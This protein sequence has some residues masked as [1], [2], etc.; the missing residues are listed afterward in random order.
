MA[1]GPDLLRRVA[2]TH[3]RCFWIDRVHPR[4]WPG[5]GSVVGWLANEDVSIAYDAAS[6]TVTRHVGGRREVVGD[7]VWAVLDAEVAAGPDDVLWVGYLGYAARPDLPAR[8]R[9]GLPDAVWL[10][11]DPRRMQQVPAGTDAEPPPSTDSGSDALTDEAAYAAAYAAVQEHLRA[12]DSYEVN[13]TYR[14]E[15]DD[16]VDPVSAYLALRRHNPAP[17]AGFLQHDVP[18][19]RAW[20]LS[21]SPERFAEV[22]ADRTIETRPIKGTL[23]RGRTPT[24]TRP[25]RRAWPTSRS[26]GRRT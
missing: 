16:A 7:D 5:H 25:S 9:S 26:S 15:V 11:A 1:D 23:P 2:A 20:L 24:R 21:S 17:Y 6:R 14:V 4:G 18:G 12:G 22:G 8:T 10:R 13:L 19:A 3:Q